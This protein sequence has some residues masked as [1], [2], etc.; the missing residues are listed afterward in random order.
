MCSKVGNIPV[1]GDDVDQNS[2]KINKYY[3]KTC[4]RIPVGGGGDDVD[5]NSLKISKYYNIF[6]Y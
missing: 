5:Q 2:L 3:N 1:G 6:N 4:G